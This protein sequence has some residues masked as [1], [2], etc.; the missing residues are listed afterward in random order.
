MKKRKLSV[1]SERNIHT[2]V[3]LHNA[4]DWVLEQAEAT[5]EGRFY[6]CMGS[7][8][9]SA[10]CIEAYLN[11]IGSKFLPYWED[12]IKKDISTQNKLKIICPHVNLVPDFSRRPFQTFKLITKYRNIMAHAISETILDRG[13][14]LIRDG[15]HII[16]PETWWEKHSKLK[17]AKRWLEDTESMITV[18]HEAAGEGGAPF[19][20]ISFGTSIGSLID[21]SMER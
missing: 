3:Y 21:N 10:F 8:I 17:T 19:L 18:I 2:Y 6:N 16:Y 15:E 4:A 20:M 14:Q 13:T 5:E 11:H 9:L 12:E 7:I 1:S